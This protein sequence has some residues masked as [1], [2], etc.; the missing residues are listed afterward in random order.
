MSDFSNTSVAAGSWS[1]TD[2]ASWNQQELLFIH[3][4]KSGGTTLDSIFRDHYFNVPLLPSTPFELFGNYIEKF[5]DPSYRYIGGHYPLSTIDPDRFYKKIT[6]LRN[7]LDS[8][9]SGISYV[10]KL[11]GL[12]KEALS[13][14]EKSGL[15]ALTY[16]KFF[17]THFDTDRYLI[18]L[19]YGI[20]KGM[21]NYIFDCAVGEA[22]E[23]IKK[24]T[25]V[26]DFE[27]FDG[28]VKRFLIQERYFPYAKIAKKRQYSYQPDYVR[29]ELLLSEFDKQFYQLSTPLFKKVPDN[30]DVL[31]EQYREDY[32]RNRGWAL[33][34]HEGTSLDLRMPLGSGW[35][36]AELTEKN[37]S[38]R[39]SEP[40]L[41]TIEI[42]IATAGLYAIYLYIN[43]A[44]VTDLTFSISTVIHPQEFA[45]TLVNEKNIL[46]YRVLVETRSH[47]WINIVINMR[48]DAQMPATLETVDVREL[49]ITLNNVYICRHS[50]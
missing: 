29:A 30:I 48:K 44:A 3:I 11:N 8:I 45:A 12:P 46:I 32:C 47:D 49:G 34:V 38:F 40:T 7:P 33:R 10:N 21:R 24:F 41:A 43:P 31:Y 27:N 19:N 2:R 28:E 6:V 15:P 20:A 35:H 16:K 9:C 37:S 36:H 39:W 1:L 25:H 42:P 4:P 13:Q 5:N 22:F 50:L 17:T 14:A 18:D 26:F 23:N